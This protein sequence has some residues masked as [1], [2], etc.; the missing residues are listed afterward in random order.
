M[1]RHA[2]G[3]TIVGTGW[4]TPTGYARA[5]IKEVG[6]VPGNH[7][8]SATQQPMLDLNDAQLTW[9]LSGQT[10]IS[11]EAINDAGWIVGNGSSGSYTRGMVLVPQ[12][13]SVQ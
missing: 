7:D 8:I 3:L 1:N 11:A 12:P 10:F 9:K 6:L 13:V 4:I 5:F 2:R